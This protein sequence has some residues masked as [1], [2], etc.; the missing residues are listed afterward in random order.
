MRLS[1]NISIVIYGLVLFISCSTP[2]VQPPAF[3]GD[4]AYG[5]L[6][7]QVEFGPRVPGSEASALC[8]DY[9]YH[10]FNGL[11]LDVDSQAFN[12]FDPYSQH[13]TTMINVIA[14]WRP[15]GEENADAIILMAHYDCRP[16]TDFASDSTLFNEPIDGASDGA[17]GVAVLMEM[18]NMFAAQPPSCRVDLVLV[19]GEDWGMSGDPDNYCLG[20]KAFVRAGIRGKYRFGFVVDL[21]GDSSQQIYRE[22]YSEQYAKALND[23][24]WNTASR[25]GIESFKDSVKFSVIDDHL[26]LN[27]A[28]VP[29]VNL[30]DL[31]Y[32][33]W[34]TE[35]D[36][37]DKCSGQSLANVG[38]VLAEIIYN[39]NL[40]PQK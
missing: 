25:L 40:W 7:K 18:A 4:R 10:H 9:L 36:T 34:H 32:S 37:P 33:W 20:S 15:D 30:I 1:R 16:R 13:D 29:T 3:D 21:I 23:V 39:P 24:V 8:R 31:D 5:Y 28:G 19:D 14:S 17:S 11:G 35:F 22:A 12:Y 27:T 6:V 38:K 2:N 26:P